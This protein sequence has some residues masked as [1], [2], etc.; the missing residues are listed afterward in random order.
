MART[1]HHLKHQGLEGQLLN[2]KELDFE[3]NMSVT[4]SFPL[5]QPIIK[6]QLTGHLIERA[7]SDKHERLITLQLGLASIS[8]RSM[9]S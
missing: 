8:D 9:I 5:R 1:Q 7:R 6:A 2:S 3:V 4:I